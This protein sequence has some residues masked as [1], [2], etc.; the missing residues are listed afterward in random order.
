M[1]RPASYP[2]PDPSK[3]TSL[4]PRDLLVGDQRIPLTILGTQA[5]QLAALAGDALNVSVR[6]TADPASGLCAHRL[7]VSA[8]GLENFYFELV[9]LTHPLH[10]VYPVGVRCEPTSL[11]VAY[12]AEGA[13]ANAARLEEFLREL[14]GQTSVRNAVRSLFAQ[15]Q[16][17]KAD[18]KKGRRASDDAPQAA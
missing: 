9:R 14:F 3:P 4:W 10:A 2:S 11:V 18:K 13:P 7:I 17:A 1:S 16:A 6:S 5:D 12:N 8:N 15:G